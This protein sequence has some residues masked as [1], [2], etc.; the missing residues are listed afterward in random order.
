MVW[1]SIN[2]GGVILTPQFLLWIPMQDMIAHSSCI[3]FDSL[4]Y[5]G[6]NRLIIVYGSAVQIDGQPTCLSSLLF[7]TLWLTPNMQWRPPFKGDFHLSITPPDLPPIIPVYSP[8][9]I[10]CASLRHVSLLLTTSD[11]T[12]PWM[13]REWP[14][15]IENSQSSLEIV[16]PLWCPC[17]VLSR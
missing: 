12:H 3:G 15:S 9:P 8:L 1:S 10:H 4:V 6:S 16:S 2:T 14:R 17:A 5:I 7:V 11:A 13:T